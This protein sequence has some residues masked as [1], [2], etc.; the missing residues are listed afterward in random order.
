M[1]VKFGA[2]II[3]FGVVGEDDLADLMIDYDEMMNNPILNRMV[4][5]LNQGRPS[6]SP[7][8]RSRILVRSIGGENSTI[9]SRDFVKINVASC[10][11]WKNS[12]VASYDS[13]GKKSRKNVPQEL[14]HLW[15][16]GYGTRTVKDY[17]EI[18]MD[19]I[20][21]DGG[22]PR[23]FCPVACGVPLKDSPIL[24]YLP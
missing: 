15:D 10:I 17:A 1:A 9:V 6:V 4:N 19:L 16:D 5:N 12:E 22:P 2:T 23:W 14:E 24:L 18:S 7:T 3:P 11:E 8:L 20:K 13:G 21:S